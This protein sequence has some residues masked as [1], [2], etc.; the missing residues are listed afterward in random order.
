MPCACGREDRV[1]EA[2][3][4]GVKYGFPVVKGVW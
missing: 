3:T 2:A 4:S 1:A